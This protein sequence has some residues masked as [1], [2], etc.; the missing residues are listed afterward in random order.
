MK[1]HRPWILCIQETKLENIDD[2][3]C[4][5]LWGSQTFGYS[6]KP[7]VGA[8][9]GI[10]TLWDTVE[11]D[12]W[13]TRSIAHV[14][15]IQGV[16]VKNGGEFSLAN[17]YAP[18]DPLGRQDVWTRLGSLLS[19]FSDFCWC[20]CG[21]FNAI[22][23]PAERESR[24]VGTIVEDYSHFNQF[25][26]SNVLFDLP[27]CDRNF[28]W[29]RGDGVSLSRLDRFLITKDWCVRWPHFIQRALIHGLSD[30]CPILLT[31]DEAN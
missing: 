24:V 13:L 25:I 15:I 2:F 8:S 11:V 16:M 7:S 14:I 18:C 31:M 3:L 29:F 5:T 28:T 10:L 21:D 27:L 6:Y 1:F 19:N 30:H 20:V 26:D 12:V 22:R 9:G 17:V 23:S 4:A